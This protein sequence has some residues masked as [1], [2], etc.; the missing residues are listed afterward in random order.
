MSGIRDRSF[1]RWLAI[2]A[3]TALAFRV[4]AAFWYD[5][6]TQVGFDG[7]WYLE[8]ARF[9]AKGIGF[10]EPTFY[11]ILHKR[12][13]TAAH[14]PL[15]PLFLSAVD[16]LG[17]HTVLAHRLW[18]C[19]PG[20]LTVVFVGI[21]ARDLAGRRAGI[22]AAGCAAVSISLAAQDVI[23]WSGGF[24][25]MTISLVVLLSYRYLRRPR[26]IGA[27]V[28]TAAVTASVLTRAE[29]ALLY[30][31]LIIPLVTI[32]VKSVRT[33]ARVLF[34]SAL[35]AAM[36]LSPWTIYNAGRFDHPVVLSTG[37]GG[38]LGHSNCPAA[39]DGPLVGSWVGGCAKGLPRRLPA[40][41]S[42]ADLLLREAAFQYAGDHLDRLPVVLAARLLRTFGIWDA[43]YQFR[44]DLYL[45][46][47]NLR[48]VSNIAV[49]QYWVYVA[50]GAVG[51]I[52]LRRRRQQLLPIV[53]PIITVVVI[54]VAGHGALRFR[55]GFDAVVPILVGVGAV[56]LLDRRRSGHSARLHGFSTMEGDPAPEASRQPATDT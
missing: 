7:A 42:S 15:Y 28:V 4:A 34:A 45:D 43:R 27:L 10:R 31:I 8:I 32:T 47:A 46:A 22:I 53:A 9:V 54:T 12:V 11:L 1:V 2:I 55:I 33:R 30:L 35:T 14:P 49:V 6:H 26:P 3:V 25:G 24:F 52:A 16:F 56:T 40:D 48:W 19:L 36:L 50:L 21:T 44:H 41:E 18:S 37:L 20:T 13:A 38:L 51:F 29:S 17:L 23:L 5:A 39:Y